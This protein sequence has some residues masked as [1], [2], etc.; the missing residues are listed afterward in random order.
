MKVVCCGVNVGCIHFLDKPAKKSLK[1]LAAE[2]VYRGKQEGTPRKKTLFYM[3]LLA[4]PLA[5]RQLLLNRINYMYSFPYLDSLFGSGHMASEGSVLLN[6]CSCS[7]SAD[8][9]CI[10]LHMDPMPWLGLG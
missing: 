9:S 5:R 7:L 3:F 10:S 8:S 2:A 6:V 4:G 1:T